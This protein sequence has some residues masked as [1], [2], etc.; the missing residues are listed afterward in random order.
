MVVVPSTTGVLCSS[1]VSSVDG[2]KPPPD[3][4]TA[5]PATGVV[6][7]TVGEGGTAHVCSG[8]RTIGSHDWSRPSTVCDV[9]NVFTPNVSFGLA[10]RPASAGGLVSCCEREPRGR[11]RVR[12]ADRARV[13]GVAPARRLDVVARGGDAEDRQRRR[14]GV[15]D[16]EGLPRAARLLVGGEEA[17]R[18][19]HRRIG[20]VGAAGDECLDRE[21][22]GVE[23]DVGPRRVADEVPP[24]VRLL[25]VAHGRQRGRR[26][27]AA[28]EALG[29]DDV[30]GVVERRADPWPCTAAHRALDQVDRRAVAGGV[31]RGR[32]EP[33]RAGAEHDVL[34]RG[35]GGQA[36]RVGIVWA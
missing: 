3:T 5:P 34:G 21:R 6:V 13:G 2:M 35:A 28:H 8:A 29:E 18:G 17:E 7:S 10:M 1:M 25:R 32:V 31:E 36:P 9:A 20:R 11:A 23:V 24:A 14:V 19:L 15:V 30:E 4:V 22:G 16:A 12:G 26:R 33:E 27:G